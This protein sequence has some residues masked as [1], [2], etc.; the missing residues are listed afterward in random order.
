M[1]YDASKKNFLFQCVIHNF[2][3]IVC[4]TYYSFLSKN[5][6]Y[7]IFVQGSSDKSVIVLIQSVEELYV[8]RLGFILSFMV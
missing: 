3:V 2:S 1:Q 8:S 6:F 7:S 4:E 5:S